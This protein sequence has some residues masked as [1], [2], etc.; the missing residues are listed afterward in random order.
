MKI[1]LIFF[2]ILL[3][4]AAVSQKIVKAVMADENG[5][6]DNAKKA[7]YLI[8]IKSYGDTAFERLDYNFAGPMQTLTTFLD[9]KLSILNGRYAEYSP[10]GFLYSEGN[11]DHNRKDGKWFVY[12]DTSHA[13]LEYKFHLDTLVS[14]INLD[15]LAKEKEK[16][17]EDTTGQFEAVYVGGVK[18]IGE[19]IQSNIQIPDRT[20]SLT[21]GGSVRVRFVVNTNGK[22]ENIEIQ[23]SVEFS[24]DEESMR[25]VALL[26]DWIPA[27]DK[28]KKVNA[29]R[30]QPITVSLK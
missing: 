19:I 6:T 29:Y 21:N 5:L 3:N 2:A 23:K 12:D 18:K 20:A 14:T 8:V 1:F 28:G 4:Y 16:I 27:S 10:S 9:S 7:K 15:S 26:K 11:Y 13:V 22:P 24:F 25:V 17:I 30:V